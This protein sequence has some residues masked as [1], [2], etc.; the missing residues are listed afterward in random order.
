MDPRPVNFPQEGLMRKSTVIA[1]VL[2]SGMLLALG[3]ACKKP[4]A[5]PLPTPKVD[6]SEARARAEAEAKR[7]AEEEARRKREEQERAEKA[8]LAELEKAKALQ[9]AAEAALKDIHFDYDKSEIKSEDKAT[10][11]GIADFLRAYPQ[12]NLLVEGHCDERG[13]VEYN[14]ALGERRAASAV[15]YLVGLGT[16]R[17]RL[18]TISYGKERPLCSEANEACWGRNRRAHFG[19]KN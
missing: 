3:L 9:R 13:T 17:A 5:A 8:R 7:R 4:S 14:I 11:Q 6:D 1:A 16:T 15:G 2:L 10:L 18:S 12:V 19:M